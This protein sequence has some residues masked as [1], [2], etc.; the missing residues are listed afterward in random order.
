[1]DNNNQQQFGRVPDAPLHGVSF[2][3]SENAEQL[4]ANAN[5]P[6]RVKSQTLSNNLRTVFTE[7]LHHKF[8][9]YSCYTKVSSR[10]QNF[11]EV[12]GLPRVTLE[13]NESSQSHNFQFPYSTYYQHKMNLI[14]L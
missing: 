3:V 4:L 2:D 6:R 1:M 5:H 14:E 13:N 8:E 7:D 11:A 9:E 12:R 10:A